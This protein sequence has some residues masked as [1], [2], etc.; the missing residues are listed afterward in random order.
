MFKI[1]DSFSP[2]LPFAG[3]TRDIRDVIT[4]C[5]RETSNAA[6]QSAFWSAAQP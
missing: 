4:S 5:K 2:F 3:N 6:A 1:E